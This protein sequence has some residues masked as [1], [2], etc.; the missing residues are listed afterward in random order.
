MDDE[1]LD[2]IGFQ[3]PEIEAEEQKPTVKPTGFKGKKVARAKAQ[4]I[5]YENLP[6]AARFI[7]D[8]LGKRISKTKPISSDEMKLLL[9]QK[10]AA[11]TIIA[12]GLGRP[13]T[14]ALPKPRS[15][16][17][18][19]VD[20]NFGDMAELKKQGAPVIEREESPAA[21]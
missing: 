18:P 9:M 6:Q 1:E 2:D 12:H 11:E 19:P 4:R 3:E 5:F 8:I 14:Q 20:F 13:G 21:D 15:D 17:P 10:D 16:A 7:T